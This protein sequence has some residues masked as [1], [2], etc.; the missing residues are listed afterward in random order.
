VRWRRR[1][2]GADVV[3]P[4]EKKKMMTGKPATETSTSRRHMLIGASSMIAATS[5]GDP[6]LATARVTGRPHIGL[7]EK[8]DDMDDKA[9]DPR[10]TRARLSGPEQVTK[11][12][13]VAELHRDGSMTVL[14]QGTYNWVCVPGDENKIG[15]PPMCMNPMGMR[16]MTDAMQGKPKPTNSVPGMIYMLCGA[17]QRSNTDAS[18]KTSVAIPIGPHWMITWPFN[19]TDNGLPTTVR[20]K[21]A[22]VMFAGTPYAYLHVCGTPWD[23]NEYREGDKAVWS[24][25]YAHR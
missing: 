12:A 16:W 22:W 19:S 17:T 21:G 13:T 24:M 20:D 6:A 9:E 1:H 4:T 7:N 14:A 10:I 15:D 3:L 11:Y 25:A 2:A 23:G 5:L 18:D 8:G